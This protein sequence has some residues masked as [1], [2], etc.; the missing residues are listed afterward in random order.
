MG[1]LQT[2]GS[3]QYFPEHEYKFCW[4]G[5]DFKGRNTFTGVNF[6]LNTQFKNYWNLNIGIRRGG[7]ELDRHEL[8]GGPSIKIPGSWNFQTG[9]GTDSRKK[10]SAGINFNLRK[11]DQ[12]YSKSASMAIRI[13]YRPIAALNLSIIPNYSRSSK[14][15]IYVSTKMENGK[16]IYLVSGIHKEI[17]SASLRVN[18]SFTPDL[19]L[20]YWGQP[21]I[22]SGDY[23][24]FKKVINPNQKV[25]TAQFHQYTTNEITYDEKTNQYLIDDNGDGNINFTLSNPDF[26]VME[27]RSNMVLRWEFVPGSTFFFVWSQ[28]KNSYSDDGAFN[29][30]SSLSQ[31]FKTHATNIFLVK[32]SYRFSM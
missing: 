24:G 6:N 26:S 21:F 18:L 3:L 1:K 31:L 14:D 12:N 16:D 20:E 27:F 17:L 22:F 15:F 29:P 4:S 11:G 9:I 2:L 7:F 28:G 30:G 5:F 32:F 19:S 25:F 23:F 13:S 8:R 10:L